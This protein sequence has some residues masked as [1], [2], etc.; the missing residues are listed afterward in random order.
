MR[1]ITNDGE[2][3]IRRQLEW[4]REACLPVGKLEPALG[5][6]RGRSD[7]KRAT[8]HVGMCDA[9]AVPELTVNSPAGGVNGIGHTFPTLYLVLAPDTGAVD[10]ALALL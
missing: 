3:L 4:D 6:E 7:R 8:T 9:A 1:E 10:N 5:R 2:D